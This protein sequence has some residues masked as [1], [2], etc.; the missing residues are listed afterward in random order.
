MPI[1][2]MP[3]L[4]ALFLAAISCHEQKGE[5]LPP[6]L[7]IK[8]ML[9]DGSDDGNELPQF[10]KLM[11]KIT[12]YSSQTAGGNCDCSGERCFKIY[13]KD[14]SLGW[15]R[16]D[17]FNGDN[18]F[19]EAFIQNLPYDCPFALEVFAYLQDSPR[20]SRYG[21]YDGITLTKGKRLFL[22][23][24]LY[25]K[26]NMPVTFN[27]GDYP[28]AIFGHTV[29]RLDRGNRPDYRVL[30]AGEFSRIDYVPDCNP[31][32]VDEEK[33]KCG[34]NPLEECFQCY[35]ATATSD[36][37]RVEQGSGKII[38]PIQ[39]GVGPVTLSTPRAFHT[40]TLLADGRVLIA[41]GVGRAV[42]IFFHNN[43]V[44]QDTSRDTGWEILNIKPDPGDGYQGALATFELFNPELNP[45]TL[46]N[47]RDGDFARGG[48]QSIAEPVT[49]MTNARFLHAAAYAPWQYDQDP[50]RE[51]IVVM[52]GGIDGQPI[53]TAA[54]TKTAEVFVLPDVPGGVAQFSNV[55]RP[56]MLLPRAFPTAAIGTSAGQQERVLWIFGGVPY[57]GNATN[58]VDP[59]GAVIEGWKRNSADGTYTNWTAAL[60][61]P[62]PAYVRLFAEAFPLNDEGSPLLVTGWY[63]ARCATVEGTETPTYDYSLAPTYICSPDAVASNFIV[64]VKNNPP[65][66]I[67]GPA[68]A[69]DNRHAF[70]ATVML[71]CNEGARGN[72]ILQSGGIA[73]TN[74][75]LS[76][77]G[78]L[79][80]LS[81]FQP[82]QNPNNPYQ[83]VT[84]FTSGLITPR[85]WHRAVELKGGSVLFIGG[86]KFDFLSKTA[87]I[88]D[89]TEL[90]SFAGQC[91]DCN[92][93]SEFN[94]ISYEGYC[95]P[96]EKDCPLTS[97]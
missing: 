92:L 28:A 42:I 96:P 83:A 23:M 38:K 86:V 56:N 88:I 51:K 65:E 18:K 97:I 30:I 87:V 67:A 33:E 72:W 20:V 78:S 76:A 59:N 13:E 91:G 4:V 90:L 26:N 17:D 6:P 39:P 9:L 60:P 43:I 64:D 68:P 44:D 19:H 10:S 5:N 49:N 94:S 53:A 89:K 15:V 52:F 12:T 73:N 35:R 47:E 27:Q 31:Y 16:L 74:F 55:T 2:R 54:A 93:E 95:C 1:G 63:G 14:P 45:D 48:I 81:L 24:I 46:D 29:T 62:Q 82:T 84:T 85:M 7:G 80:A 32:L 70:G 3:T 36:L 71:S 21:R 58:E 41:G 8:V 69:G 77:S 40:A 11:I 57:P 37:L 66:V 79:G 50:I 61:T 75:H 22:P 25:S 34:G